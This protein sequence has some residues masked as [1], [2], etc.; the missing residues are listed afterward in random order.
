[1]KNL[2]ISCCENR[3]NRSQNPFFFNLPKHLAAA[4]VITG[5]PTEALQ[6]TITAMAVA[7]DFHRIPLFP[8]AP[9]QRGA[10]RGNIINIPISCL[11]I[12]ATAILPYLYFFV[13]IFRLRLTAGCF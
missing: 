13:N 9:S 7:A 12:F 8:P 3:N 10:L 5:I 6:G 2:G 11:F 4:H 1:M